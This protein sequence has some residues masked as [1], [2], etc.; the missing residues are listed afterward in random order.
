[1]PKHELE[2]IISGLEQ[3]MRDAARNLQFEEAAALRDQ[4]YQLRGILA[5]ESGLPPWKAARL[6][7]GEEP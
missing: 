7:A 4:I 6:L 2:R 3:Q 1:M 5:D